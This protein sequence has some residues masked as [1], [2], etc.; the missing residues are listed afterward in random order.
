MN[1]PAFALVVPGPCV[2][3]KRP[4]SD[5]SLAPGAGLLILNGEGV[6]AATSAAGTQVSAARLNAF[7]A[8]PPP[9]VLTRPTCL[10]QGYGPWEEQVSRQGSRLP[11]R[12]AREVAFEFDGPHRAPLMTTQGGRGVRC[13]CL[14][15]LGT[16]LVMCLPHLRAH[17]PASHAHDA[18]QPATGS[19][20]EPAELDYGAIVLQLQGAP[21]AALGPSGLPD[22]AGP[23]M[24]P[25]L[26]EELRSQC[27]CCRLCSAQNDYSVRAKRG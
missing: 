27:T 2:V 11:L 6:R 10:N 15:P 24:W 14:V 7:T 1:V 3:L 18:L 13:H 4:A 21:L 5:S 22:G 9:P 19:A 8:P 25:V 16:G 23:T 17:L 20:A 26:P 12:A